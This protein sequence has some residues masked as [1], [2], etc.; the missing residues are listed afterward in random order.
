MTAS[1]LRTETSDGVLRVTIDRPARLNALDEVTCAAL[2]DAFESAEDIHVVVLTGSGG[3]FSAGADV[4]DMATN[5]LSDGTEAQQAA[6]HTMR[7]ANALI[8]AIISCPVPVIAQVNGP[9]V[10]IGASMALASDLIYASEEAYFLLAFTKIGL[11][12]DGAS[13]LL[14]PAAVGRARANAMMM[15]AERMSAQDAFATGLINGVFPAAELSAR[16]DTAVR[17][18]SR[19]PKR[20]LELTK[21]ALTA[22]TLSLLDDALERESEGQIELLTSPAFNERVMAIASPPKGT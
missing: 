7:R 18:L 22:S 3:S 20:A 12:P 17:R 9:A 15:L 8:R 19:A 16:V 10:G 13:S 21:R 1:G 4:I 11:M 6:E 14:V 5:S 2:T